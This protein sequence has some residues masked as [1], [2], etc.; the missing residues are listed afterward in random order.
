M[1]VGRAVAAWCELEDL[2]RCDHRAGQAGLG[3]VLGGR[4]GLG[5]D[6]GKVSLAPDLDRR[7]LQGGLLGTGRGG[8]GSTVG[9]PG[10]LT[11]RWE[12]GA[13]RSRRRWRPGRAGLGRGL[14]GLGDAAARWVV[15][16]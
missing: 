15:P 14:G 4:L 8:V 12:V 2:G 5:P 6:G 16:R 3:E 11:V 7:D 9:S 1:G 10:T 13:I